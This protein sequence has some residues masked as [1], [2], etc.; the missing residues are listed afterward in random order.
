MV[1]QPGL[2]QR[3]GVCHH[4]AL[5]LPVCTDPVKFYEYADAGRFQVDVLIFLQI[6][7]HPDEFVWGQT[8]L[9]QDAPL[10]PK[11]FPI[12]G[13]AGDDRACLPA[14]RGGRI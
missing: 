11:D 14:G 13:V 7:V 9:F 2:E 12:G 6:G 4:G 1:D 3:S 5:G 10:L 8:G